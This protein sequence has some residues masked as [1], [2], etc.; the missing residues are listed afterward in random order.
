VA[1]D[2]GAEARAISSRS[3]SLP[4][5][6]RSR[7]SSLTRAERRRLGPPPRQRTSAE[8]AVDDVSGGARL[9]C[10]R[11]PVFRAGRRAGVR[12][13]TRHNICGPPADRGTLMRYGRRK[14]LRGRAL[15]LSRDGDLA[16]G[17]GRRRRARALLEDSS[18]QPLAHTATVIGLAARVA[19][20]PRR[21]RAV[22]AASLRHALPPA[23]RR[24]VGSAVALVAIAARADPHEAPALSTAEGAVARRDPVRSPTGRTR[25]NELA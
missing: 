6:S 12:L 24:A 16:R 9:G 13:W 1:V 19:G 23:D 8:D 14:I 10:R 25:P 20:L 22:D 2:A 11:V 7:S 5:A 18:T 15:R 3:W 21:R 17:H 4:R